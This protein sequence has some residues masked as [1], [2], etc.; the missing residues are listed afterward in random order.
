M[1][2][3]IQYIMDVVI[4]YSVQVLMAGRWKKS[5]RADIHIH[6]S[7]LV[8]VVYRAPMTCKF[9]ALCRDGNMLGL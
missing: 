6:T 4:E 8:T 9:Q 1:H 3:Y 5:T 7:K 2:T